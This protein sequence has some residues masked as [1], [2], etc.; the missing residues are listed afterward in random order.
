MSAAYLYKFQGP[1]QKIALSF[2]GEKVF[3]RIKESFFF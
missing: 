2:E 1:Y 3:I